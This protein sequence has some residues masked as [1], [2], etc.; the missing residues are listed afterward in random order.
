[1]TAQQTAGPV[2]Q[3]PA[4]LPRAAMG[5]FELAFFVVAAAGPLLVVAGYA[6]L[7]LSLGGIAAPAAQLVAGL[8]LLL[9]SVGFTRMALRI[10]NPG[11]FYSYIGRSLGKPLGGGAALLAMTA[12]SLIAIGQLGAFGSF[13]TGTVERLTGLTLP[14]PVCSAIALAVVAF[15]GHR[16]ISFSARVLGVALLAEVAVLMALA[17]PVLLTGGG[18]DGLTLDSFDPSLLLAGG[19]AGA[20]FTIAF[21]AF[22]GFEST[23]VYAEEAREPQRTVPRATF[24]AIGFLTVF[25]TFMM[26]IAVVAFGKAGAVDIATTDPVG[27]FFVATE[28]YVGHWA[29]VTMEMLLITSAFASILA[30]HNTAARYLFNLGREG[31]LPARLASVH[32]RHGSPWM[33]S[34]VQAAAA[35]VLVA[36]FALAGADPY[37]DLFL[38]LSSPGIVA[39]TLLQAL[40]AVAIA[41]YFRRHPAESGSVWTTLVAPLAALVG[42]CWAAWLILSNFELLTGRTDWVNTLLIGVLPVVFLAG[43]LVVLRMRGARPERYAHLIERE[44]LDSH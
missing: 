12:Y 28:Q 5:T 10:N 19:G 27:M 40:C 17:L 44:V 24:L 23:A 43:M 29:T 41:V 37:L 18:P 11:A 42:L 34:G 1:M 2:Q 39:V 4:A 16:R 3:E 8:V 36:A 30:F 14:W 15:L 31:L 13:A 35:I 21:G 33:A 6:P 38:W 9:F 26:W 32:P 22:A 20:M 25:Y 7:A